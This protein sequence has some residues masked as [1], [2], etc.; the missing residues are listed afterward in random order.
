MM[1]SKD[2]LK[3]AE[4]AINGWIDMM[5]SLGYLD[6]LKGES[7]YEDVPKEWKNHDKNDIL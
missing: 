6:L 1:E 5:D 3:F 7:E 2:F 4:K